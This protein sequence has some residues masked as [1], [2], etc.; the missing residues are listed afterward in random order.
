LVDYGLEPAEPTR[1]VPNPRRKEIDAQIQRARVQLAQLEAEY[2]I[3]AFENPEA[4]RRTMRGFKIANSE[5]GQRLRDA[6]KRVATLEKQRARIPARVPVQE[7]VQGEVIQLATERKHLTDLLK[8][9]AYQAEGDLLRAVEPHYRRSDD[10][11]RTFIQS[12]L[13]CSGDLSVT[14]TELHVALQ[15]LSSPHRTRVL[16][17]LCEHLNATKTCYPGTKLRLRFS[18]QNEAPPSMAFPGARPSKAG[19]EPGQPDSL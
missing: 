1:S 6:M 17:A 16:A 11:G 9:V 12:A 13:A 18:V 14:E 2:G 10:E 5:L 15:P 3:E 4:R 7:V 8:M 19:S